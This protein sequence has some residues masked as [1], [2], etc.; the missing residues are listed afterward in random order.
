MARPKKE[1][2]IELKETK[3]EEKEVPKSIVETV[4]KNIETAKEQGTSKVQSRKIDDETMIAV[5][6]FASGTTNFKNQSEPYDQYVFE[7][8]GAIEDI[9]FGSLRDLRR[10]KGEEPFKRFLYVLDED[11]VKALGLEK[12]YSEIGRL[13]DLIKIYDKDLQTVL[14]FIDRANPS[15]KRVL[16]EIYYNKLERKERIDLFEARAIA[17]KLGIELNLDI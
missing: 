11:A 17:E 8:F 1:E 13:E 12:V 6:S 4:E 9:R 7:G 2:V 14:N 16:T 15:V 5:A 3:V 10:K